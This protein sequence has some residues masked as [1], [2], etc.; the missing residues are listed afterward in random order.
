MRA[1]DNYHHGNLRNLLLGEARRRLEAEGL[2]ALSLR[3][4]AENAGVSKSAPYRHF[5]NKHELLVALAADGFR[6]FAEALDLSMAASRDRPALE[7]LR[8][9]ARAYVD[10]ARSRP[11]LYRLMFSRFGYSLHSEACRENS[12]RALACL[13][14]AVARAQAEG[15]KP[16]QDSGALVLSIWAQ[17]HG[18]VGLLIDGLVPEGTGLDGGSWRS[19]VEALL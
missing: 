18:A 13:I 4:L 5:A 3:A 11:A 7:G 8:E 1:K 12:L 15:W 16:G 10:F 14:E 19:F 17:V 6:E 9:L 2:E